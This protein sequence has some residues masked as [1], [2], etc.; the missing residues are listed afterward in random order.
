MSYSP[1]L[2]R[3]LEADPLGYP[4]GPNR[5]AYEG[6]A[7][8]STL[9]S[10]G[11][12]P[13]DDD[14][15]FN[16]VVRVESEARK[17]LEYYGG[18]GTSLTSVTSQPYAVFADGHREAISD[19][20][21][22]AYQ[23]ALRELALG[24]Q[25]NQFLGPLGMRG[26]PRRGT[27]QPTTTQAGAYTPS[28]AELEKLKQLDPELYEYYKAHPEVVIMRPVNV[29]GSPTKA[30]HTEGNIISI[31]RRFGP[32]SFCES[33]IHELLHH[34]KGRLVTRAEHMEIYRRQA[35]AIKKNGRCDHYPGM[36]RQ[37]SSGEWELDEDR[38]NRAINAEQGGN[39]P[40]TSATQP[41]TR[42]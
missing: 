22:V 4:D 40:S 42:P 34:Q 23:D 9:D 16:T 18:E 31:K 24:G 33:L 13:T 6:N 8:A 28:D 20:E 38:L 3:F 19:A 26:V 37:N 27:T 41:S 21:A 11:L 32:D 7:P 12:T 2:G 35:E 29:Q 5:Y 10:Q 39:P 25:P 1:N 30:G 36:F 17:S 14:Q 15:A